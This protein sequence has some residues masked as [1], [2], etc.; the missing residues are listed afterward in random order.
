MESGEPGMKDGGFRPNRV[1]DYFRAEWRVLLAVSLSGV[2]YNVGLIAAPWFEG[3]M[4]GKLV[5]ILTRGGR[6]HAMLPLAVGYG[7]VTL[8]VQGSRFVKRFYVRRFAN[9]VNRRM[10]ALL[11][12]S[13]VRKSREA[14][15]E[16]GEGGILTRALA[17]VDDCVEGMRKFTTE[18]FDTGVAL[19]AYSAMLLAYDWRLALCCMIFPPISYYSA[20][21]L[22]VSVQRSG[23]ALKVQ[24]GK[25]NAETL[26]RGRNAVTYRV[27]GRE[28]A[29]R[30]DY[31]KNLADYEAAAVRAGVWKEMMP[32]L[33]RVLSG[34]GV[35]FVFWFGQKNVLGTGW[36]SWDIGAFTAF[37]SCFLRLAAKSASAGKLFNAVQK[38][39]VSWKRLKPVLPSE[40]W[41]EEPVP[42]GA[43]GELR[44]ENLRYGY[45]ER[46]ILD[47]ISFSLR[48]G[49][50]L[51]ITGEVACGKS[52]LGKVFLG[53]G[54]YEGSVTFGGRELG[55]LRP[56][57]RYARVGYLGHDPEL[58]DCGIGENVTLGGAED[59]MP[60]LKA[61]CLEEEVSQMEAGLSTLVGSG[62]IRL[63]GGQAQRLALARTLYNRRPVLILDDPFSAL[64]RQTEEEI[65][66]NLRGLTQDS[67]VILLSHRL[68]LFPKL[69]QVGYLERG[70]LTVGTHQELMERCPGYRARFE[71]QR[72]EHR[73]E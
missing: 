2:V 20:E 52:T 10:K 14:L 15:G 41:R 46:P 47:G 40:I 7:L 65:F 28:E 27:Y 18:L 9:N 67:G 19:L 61:V 8:V 64:D 21:K 54:A 58:F 50:I 13:L 31:E 55:Q 4:T 25:L 3:A 70:K 71:E 17:D 30:A 24:N 5:E 48:P 22:K 11:F 45:G 38:A 32:P 68:Y 29:R 69:S 16:E 35:L 36:S 72:G 6:F 39:Q 59:P 37:L 44:V 51:G 62:G 33:Y 23:A 66:E 73:E 12:G 63:S 57:E 60:Y 56:G 53:E 1:A 26:D 49:Q 43:A 34:A 42:K